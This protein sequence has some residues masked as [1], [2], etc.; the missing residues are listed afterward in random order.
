MT[1]VAAFFLLQL[2][3]RAPAHVLWLVHP[4]V[5]LYINTPN[6]LALESVLV[7][8]FLVLIHN[9]PLLW[10][11]SYHQAKH[12]T[13]GRNIESSLKATE[14][15]TIEHSFIPSD[16]TSVALTYGLFHISSSKVRT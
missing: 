13:K 9:L 14:D 12:S 10:G 11:N 5:C 15:E 8:N 7:L 4:V 2:K 1:I 3:T 16:T 6:I